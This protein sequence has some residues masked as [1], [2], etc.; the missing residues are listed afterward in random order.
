MIVVKFFG[1]RSY[2]PLDRESIPP[3][4]Y[5]DYRVSPLWL[6]ACVFVFEAASASA[7]AEFVSIKLI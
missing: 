3:K 1:D 4:K 6:R 7:S 2:E 5:A